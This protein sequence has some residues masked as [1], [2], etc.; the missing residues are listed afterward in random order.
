MTAPSTCW[1]APA[2][3][4]TA[5]SKLVR[6]DAFM[7]EEL[8]GRAPGRFTLASRAPERSLE[9]GGNAINFA[10]VG[11][12]PNCADLE[13]GRRPGTHAD[14]L[15]LVRLIHSLDAIHLAAARRWCRSTCRPKPAISTATM[16]SSR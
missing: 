8:V 11:G 4:S 12:P 5:A 1:R 14:F 15:D 10:S 6:F 3:G 2:P 13:R 9:V 16:P 7:I